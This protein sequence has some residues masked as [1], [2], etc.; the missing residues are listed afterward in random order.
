MLFRIRLFL[1]GELMADFYR[2]HG[3]GNDYLVIDPNKIKLKMTE[4]IVQKICDRHKGIGSDGILYG[5]IL[6]NEKRFFRI[7][8]PDGSESEKSGNGIRIFAKY[9]LDENYESALD[10]PLQTLAGSVQVEVIDKKKGLLKVNMGKYTVL[11]GER[12]RH[13]ENFEDIFEPLNILDSCFNITRISVG[14][15]HCVILKEDL[16]KDSTIKYGPH[17]ET[18]SLFPNRTNVQFVKVLDRQ[19]IQIEI[20]ERG[21]G[22]T[23]ASGTSSCAAASAC[24]ELGRVDNTVTVIMPGGKMTVEI[25]RDKELFLTGP[26]SKICE[27]FFSEDFSL[28][29]ND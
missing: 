23:L 10:F 13:K 5:P 8:N 22:Y 11:K 25:T 7:F 24:F 19:S 20:W 28:E 6:K 26:V 16:L 18:H 3:L 12:V 27:G 9:L 29:L 2:Y 15:P 21:A 17:I 1:F 14:N 4:K